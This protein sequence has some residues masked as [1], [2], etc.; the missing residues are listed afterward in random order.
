[1]LSSKISKQRS[2]H[3]PHFANLEQLW[4]SFQA[5]FW[6]KIRCKF[7]YSPSTLC[8]LRFP[9]F[10]KE[11]QQWREQRNRWKQN[12]Y[13]PTQHFLLFFKSRT[14]KTML[15]EIRMTY[16]CEPALFLDIWWSSVCFR[17]SSCT[18]R[19]TRCICC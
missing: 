11:R 19:T 12:F 10:W 6:L 15:D 17:Y 9:L 13:H 1:M 7:C 18:W 5:T 2:F 16:T 14:V 8:I 3:G 4:P